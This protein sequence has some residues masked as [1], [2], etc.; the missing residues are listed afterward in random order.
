MLRGMLDTIR[1]LYLD[2][3]KFLIFSHHYI[4]IFGAISITK[5]TIFG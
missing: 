4:E 2:I 1:V 3:V 5:K